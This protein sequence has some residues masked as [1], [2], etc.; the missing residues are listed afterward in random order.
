[1]KGI[2]YL[3]CK[4]FNLNIRESVVPAD[5][6]HEVHKLV[7]HFDSPKC[8]KLNSDEVTKTLHPIALLPYLSPLW[9]D[10]PLRIRIEVN[11]LRVGLVSANAAVREVHKPIIRENVVAA[12]DAG[13]EFLVDFQEY[14]YSLDM[15]SFGCMF[16]SMIFRKELFFHGHDNY[17]QLVKIAK[18]L[19]M[20]EL[21]AYVEK[22]P[23]KAWARFVTSSEAIDFLDIG[24]MMDQD[25][26]S[27]RRQRNWFLNHPPQFVKIGYAGS[28]Y[29]EHVFPSIIG[30]PILRAE[31]HVGSAVT[32]PMEHG[33]VHNPEDMKHLWDYT[34]DAKLKVDPHGRK[35]LLMEPPMN[36]KANRQWMVQVMFEEYG[37]QGVY[38]AIQTVLALYAEGLTTGVVVDSGDG[39]THIVPVYEG[40]ALPHPTR[41][42]DIAGR[43]VTRYLTKLLLMRG[44]AFNR[45]ADFETVREIKEKLCYVS[46][47]LD[48]DQRLS[49]ETT[50]LVESYTLPDGRTIKVGSERFE[51]PESSF[52]STLR[53]PAAVILLVVGLSWPCFRCRSLPAGSM[54]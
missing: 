47:D 10:L 21:N 19:G 29:P 14:D 16:A 54:F 53:V 11:L 6:V 5:A 48:L 25:P 34:F 22:Y 7:P 26:L 12:I 40:F 33:I 39:V 45:T 23:R 42:L 49:E 50:V 2:C 37:F 20:D 52:L 17:D 35:V 31:E 44:Y 18:V 27:R 3:A 4:V 28:N 8:N 1:M 32:Q 9:Y 46:Y 43:D 41:C 36:P 15:W 24:A 30:R 51:A 38:V 13:P